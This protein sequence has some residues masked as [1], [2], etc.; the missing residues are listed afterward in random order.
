[1]AFL[2]LHTHT[3]TDKA[4][5]HTAPRLRGGET[6]VKPILNL[7]RRTCVVLVASHDTC[8]VSS[9]HHSCSAWT[10][11]L[12]PPDLAI[13]SYR[14]DTTTLYAPFPSFNPC[15]NVTVVRISIQSSWHLNNVVHTHFLALSSALLS[16]PLLL[17]EPPSVL[18]PAPASPASANCKCSPVV[19]GWEDLQYVEISCIE[20]T[21]LLGYIGTK[22][23]VTRLWTIKLLFGAQLAT[24][25]LRPLLV[26]C[27]LW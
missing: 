20:N 26:K 17:H 9:L 5:V 25:I 8:W 7:F 15:S 1:M 18:S 22:I 6:P 21:W 23:K 3:H 4:H 24:V 12:T 16:I 14:Y 27:F 11:P 13:D 2:V 19:Q 10:Q